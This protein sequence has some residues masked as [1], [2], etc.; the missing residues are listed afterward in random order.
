MSGV[1]CVCPYI[2]DTPVLEREGV[3]QVTVK[4]LWVLSR[5]MYYP[6]PIYKQLTSTYFESTQVKVL[7]TH[8]SVWTHIKYTLVF[9][10]TDIDGS[11]RPSEDWHTT[12]L[13]GH[14]YVHPRWRKLKVR[15]NS[16]VITSTVNTEGYPG[17]YQSLTPVGRR[18]ILLWWGRDFSPKK[19]NK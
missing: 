5:P 19:T 7:V 17:L 16:V 4:S 18:C 11:I 10:W 13:I 12:S 9:G 8:D 14:V 3:K 15:E 2:Q 1:V 6:Q